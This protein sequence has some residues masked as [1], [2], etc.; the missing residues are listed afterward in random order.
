MTMTMEQG[1]LDFGSG[2]CSKKGRLSKFKEKLGKHLI[3]V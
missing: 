2:S 1:L 3:A